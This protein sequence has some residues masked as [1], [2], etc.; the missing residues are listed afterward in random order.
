MSPRLA[1]AIFAAPGLLLLGLVV[2]P[3]VA[4]VALTPPEDVVSGLS[5]PLAEPAFGLSL[6]T[7]SVSLGVIAL[8]GT[9]LAWALAQ[10]RPTALLPRLVELLLAVPAVLPPAVAGVGLLLAFGSRGLVAHLAGPDLWPGLGGTTAAVVLAE[11]F[12][13]SP[14]FMSAA[15]GAFRA[16]APEQLGAARTLGASPLGLF[17]RVALPVARRGLIAGAAM[18]WARA[19]GEFGA[20]LM[21]AGSVEG[22]TQTLPLALYATL[23]D[24]LAA[25]RAIAAAMLVFAFALLL[26]LRALTDRRGRVQVSRS[27]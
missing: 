7:T 26:L 25:T 1:N 22:R 6:L 18:A 14:F 17:F 15:V 8:L 4:L 5:H 9:P 19:L 12:V 2:L 13:A 11:V 24:D 16:V 3:V 27:A 21:F 10:A 20:T 23:E